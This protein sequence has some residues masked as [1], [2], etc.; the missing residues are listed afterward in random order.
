MKALLLAQLWCWD[1]RNQTWNERI[2]CL[3]G[4]SAAVFNQAVSGGSTQR[5]WRRRW[6]RLGFLIRFIRR[7]GDHRLFRVWL[8]G[9]INDGQSNNCSDSLPTTQ[10]VKIYYIGERNIRRNDRSDLRWKNGKTVCLTTAQALLKF[11]INNTSASTAKKRLMLKVS[12]MSMVT[13][14]FGDRSGAGIRARTFEKL[15]EKWAG[16]GPCGYC[17]CQTEFTQENFAVSTSVGPGAANLLTA[18]GTAFA[19]NIPV[20]LPADTF[21]TRQPDPVLQQLEHASSVAFRQMMHFKRFL[22][23][24]TASI[25]QSSWCP[26]Y[27]GPL[28]SWRTRQRWVRQRFVCR[29]TWRQKPMPIRRN[30]Q[31]S[32]LYW[33]QDSDRS[34]ACWSESTNKGQ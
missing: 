16:N 6:L 12:F 28:K 24:G 26:R 33:S 32:T 31:K 27:C 23:T 10:E 2:D 13:E 29:R 3:Y 30:F 14:M 25:D 9:S 18:A 8:S 20:L 11:W 7:L 21:A 22:A 5:L 15:A 17:L 1:C 4:R 19:N 34:W